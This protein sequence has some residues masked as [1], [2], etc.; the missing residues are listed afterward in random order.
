MMNGMMIQKL[1]QKLLSCPQK[2]QMKQIKKQ[3]K[4]LKNKPM[5]RTMN[6]IFGKSQKM[7]V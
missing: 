3:M 1:E 5:F 7:I 2:M 6:I 4:L